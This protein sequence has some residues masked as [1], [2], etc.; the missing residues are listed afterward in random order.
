M[1]NQ[2]AMSVTAAVFV[3][4]TA[5]DAAVVYDQTQ[6]GAVPGG[7]T[8]LTFTGAIPPVGDATLSLIA[9]G[10]EL[11]LNGKRLDN[12]TVDGD[13][14]TTPGGWPAGYFL[15]VNWLDQF[16]DPVAPITIPLA[17]LAT[18]AADGE[19]VITVTKPGFL[20]G[21]T[22]DVQLT[23]EGTPEPA[24]VALMALASVALLRRR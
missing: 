2:I 17:N 13:T 22:F 16:G 14:Y 1:F 8:V 21:G 5:T 4:A 7:P 3:V 10:G 12:L 9:T 15:P 24:S 19:I 6:S 23:Y 20:A 18:Y 11:N